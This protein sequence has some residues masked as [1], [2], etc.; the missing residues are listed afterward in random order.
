M[1]SKVIL[2]IL[3]WVS[4]NVYS[5]AYRLADIEEEPGI[6]R[7]VRRLVQEMD[8][9]ARSTRDLETFGFASIVQAR[10]LYGMGEKAL[11]E[12]L[13]QIKNKSL[14]SN[15]RFDMISHLGY[16]GYVRKKYLKEVIDSL[17]KM[18]LDKSEDPS[19]RNGICGYFFEV[20]KDTHATSYLIQVMEDKSNPERVRWWAAHAFVFIPDE[21]AVKPL[22]KNLDEDP[23]MEVKKISI[24]A[25]G[26][27]GRKTGNKDM[28]PKLMGI[29][30]DKGR[31][32]LRYFAISALGAMKEDRLVPLLT[33]SIKN[34]DKRDF[35]VVIWALGNIG[36]PECK[37]ALLQLLKDEDE[38]VRYDAALS[39]LKMRDKSVIPAIESVIPT[40][41]SS[42]F[43]K[44]ISDSLNNLIRRG[45][46]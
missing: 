9:I 6:N 8:L 19:V 33:Q 41:N 35:D 21:R 31:N 5:Q 42:G 7:K 43:R 27:I 39:L 1:R 12:M 45:Q 44:V 18:L 34:K 13:R 37:E 22:L 23:S 26:A 28:V 10:E 46:K 2:L 38:G 15:L 25:L 30:E 29:V 17:G 20:V 32:P 14:H 11:P 36:T 24:S 16:F 3:L 4:L 40:F